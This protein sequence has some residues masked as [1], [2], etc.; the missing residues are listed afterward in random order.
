MK[1][2]AKYLRRTRMKNGL[3]LLDISKR[4]DKETPQ[5]ISNIENCRAK[6]PVRSIKSFAEAYSVD[7]EVLLK[8]Y[9][10]D[11]KDIIRSKAGL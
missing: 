1:E 6:V 7:P 9:F 8:K 2:T 11:T 4:L 5:F 3:T 10:L